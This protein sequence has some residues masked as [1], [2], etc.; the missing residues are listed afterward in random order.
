MARILYVVVF[1]SGALGERNEAVKAAVARSET[2]T[3]TLVDSLLV[4]LARARKGN[5]EQVLQNEF[6]A[7]E[8]GMLRNTKDSEMKDSTPGQHAFVEGSARV[9]EKR[10]EDDCPLGPRMRSWQVLIPE[11]KTADSNLADYYFAVGDPCKSEYG[12]GSEIWKTDPPHSACE[13]AFLAAIEKG[14]SD[15]SCKKLVLWSSFVEFHLTSYLTVASS[16]E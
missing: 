6:L 14:G 1:V 9:V 16:I 11:Y 5:A 3:K 8:L 12:W 15:Q 7:K 4:E 2:A 13:Q 10:T